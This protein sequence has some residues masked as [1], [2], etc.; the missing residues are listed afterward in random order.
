M[1]IIIAKK[2]GFCFGVEKA[3]AAAEKLLNAQE[4]VYCLGPL[5]HNSQVVEQLAKE[6]LQV[7]ENL[8]Q[9]EPVQQSDN[10]DNSS[11][12]TVLI[13]SHGCRPELLREV[14][15]RGFRLVDATCVLVRRVQNLVDELFRQGY[16]VIVVGDPDHPEI[17]GVVG[18]APEVV[19]V[20]GPDDLDK[21]PPQGKL[22]I[23]SQTTYSAE[24]FGQ[25]VGLI[26]TRGY[27]EIKVVNTICK[28]TA[29]R[30]ESAIEL[31]A[32][33]DV[34]FVLGSHHSANT[35]ELAELCRKNNIETY[36]LQSWQEF[37][38]DFVTGKHTIGITAGASTPDW[39]IR[40]FVDNLE[41]FDARS[42]RGH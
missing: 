17:K 28:E 12:P 13:R 24:D 21:L 20:N 31:C 39:V 36:H 42:R 2:S 26:A 1:K 3:I 6:G 10:K 25:T 30:Q 34:I 23:V 18:Y 4:K 8:D 9:I 27:E 11:R 5:I 37:K 40:E 41:N 29:R 38:T 7:V 32:Q 19:V 15:K 22:A 16:Q 14:E 35:R 33:V